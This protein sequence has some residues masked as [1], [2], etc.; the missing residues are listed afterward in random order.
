MIKILNI[1]PRTKRDKTF[2]KTY[3]PYC[4]T[5]LVFEFGDIWW[6]DPKNEIGRIKCPV[7]RTKVHVSAGPA[8]AADSYI[9]P[10]VEL[11][12][13]TEKEYVTANKDTSRSGLQI[14][15]D[16]KRKEENE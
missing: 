2:Y 5:I 4:S 15:L 14:L 3:C 13:A 10:I 6:D 8:Y 12:K 16:E 11:E 9:L 1:G 7:C